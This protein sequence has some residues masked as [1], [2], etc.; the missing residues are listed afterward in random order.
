MMVE[1]FKLLRNKGVPY[2]LLIVRISRNTCTRQYYNLIA[3]EAE[4]RGLSEELNIY[5]TSK[6]LREVN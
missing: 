1:E 3:K 2:I 6:T 5:P 4:N